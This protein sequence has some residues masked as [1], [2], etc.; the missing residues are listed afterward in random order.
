MDVQIIS[1]KPLALAEVGG[2]LKGTK[3][4]GNPIQQ[5][6]FDFASKYG[7]ITPSDCKKLVAKLEGL[8][9][10]RMSPEHIAEIASTLPES[11]DALKMVFAASKTTLKQED[12]D[13][14][15]NILKEFK[16]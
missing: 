6:T 2:I 15:L 16:A 3:K 12:L 10:S 5:K 4:D 7:K 14:V 1:K 13:A 9:I 8:G 11:A